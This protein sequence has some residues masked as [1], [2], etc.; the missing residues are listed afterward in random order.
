MNR[1]WVRRKLDCIS[2]LP[3]KWERKVIEK[4]GD[5][6]FDVSFNVRSLFRRWCSSSVRTPASR[7][8]TEFGWSYTGWMLELHR[9]KVTI[10]LS[11]DWVC[12]EVA[13]HNMHEYL[14]W[15]IS[16]YNSY[17]RIIFRHV[18]IIYLCCVCSSYSNIVACMYSL[19][20]CMS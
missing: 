18:P 1:I 7:G 16:I 12:F 13:L 5:R 3:M 8:V 20:V 10:P 6:N 4:W 14:V 17:G 11:F 15:I 2:R 9:T 19:P